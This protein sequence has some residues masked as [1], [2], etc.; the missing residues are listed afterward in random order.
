[1]V[2]WYIVILRKHN[3]GNAHVSTRFML[4]YQDRSVDRIMDILTVKYKVFSTMSS[5]IT[6]F[7]INTYLD[8]PYLIRMYVEV[9]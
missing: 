4:L 3:V 5:I 6:D 2:L 9:G 8:Q 7:Q 1:M